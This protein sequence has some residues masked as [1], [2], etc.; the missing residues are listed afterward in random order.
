[1]LILHILVVRITFLFSTFLTS[2]LFIPH[3][4]VM[5]TVYTAPSCQVYLFI[6]HLLV[7][8]LSGYLF[9]RHLLVWLPF[10]TAPSCQVYIFI[11]HLLVRF[12]VYLWH[13]LSRF[14]FI[15]SYNTFFKLFS[16]YL[17]IRHFLALL[18]VSQ[19]ISA[20]ICLFLKNQ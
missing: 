19:S 16:G 13:L 1:M 12:T 8:F 17:F 2:Y 5:F 18:S 10:Y 3:F 7:N 14:L 9:I 4:L 15:C 6:G 20:H 11:R